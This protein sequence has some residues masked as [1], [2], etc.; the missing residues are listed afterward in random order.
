MLKHP[1]AIPKLHGIKNTKSHLDLKHKHGCFRLA[2]GQKCM[3]GLG[4]M[5]RGSFQGMFR[6]M[7]RVCFVGTCLLTKG[8]LWGYV[9]RHVSRYVSG[10]VSSGSNMRPYMN[11]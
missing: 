3:L 11:S 2:R 1:K 4:S 8:T 6:G 9:A 7:C 10:Y 5:F